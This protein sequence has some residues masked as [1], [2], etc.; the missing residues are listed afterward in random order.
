MGYTM[1]FE[2]RTSGPINAIIFDRARHAVGRIEQ[3]RRGLRDRVVAK[4]P[5]CP[6]MSRV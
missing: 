2:D 4:N 5:A 6:R 1:T 3:P